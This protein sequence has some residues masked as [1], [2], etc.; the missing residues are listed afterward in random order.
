MRKSKSPLALLHRW[1][2]SGE[3]PR[4]RDPFEAAA[5]ASA[6]RQQG[7]AG[8][9]QDAVGSE[10]DWPA[11]AREGLAQGR[12]ASLVAG[13]RRLDLAA[14]V[15]NLLESKGLRALPL[16]G[17]ALS[18]RLYDSVADR[19][20]ADVDV[21]VLDD[22][23]GARALLREQGFAELGAADHAVSFADPLSGGVVE[24]H[25]D[26]TSCPGLFPLDREG[27][28][29][30]SK[31]A[32]GQVPRIPSSEDLLVQISL[33]AA[34]QHGLVLSL[35]QYL[36]FRRLLAR[37]EVDPDRAAAI[38]AASRAETSVAAALRAAE[39]V[40]GARVPEAL[41]QRFRSRVPPSLARWL[42]DRLRDPL[43]LVTP[44]TPALARLRWELVPGRRA[45]LVR[46]SIFVARPGPSG[47]LL[48]RALGPIARASHL[49]RRWALPAWRSWSGAR[50]REDERAASPVAVRLEG[51]ET[52]EPPAA[53]AEAILADCLRSFAHVR[54]TVTGECMGPA[55]R[56]GDTVLVAEPSRRP[57]RFGDVVLF[58]HPEGLR[59]HRLVW[60]PPL[61]GIG[62]AWRTKGDRARRWDPH[63]SSGDVLG[64]VIA[65][66]G[67]DS[68]AGVPTALR[69][70]AQAL[71]ASARDRW[72]AQARA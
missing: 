41:A 35:V 51:A 61:A 33:H 15:L 68:A 64:T 59:L 9:L 25:Q 36:D 70:L 56:P 50:P 19:P 27:L 66:E 67:R 57:P 16:K 5:I 53:T 65:V 7:V 6:A 2:V 4:T 54:L 30:R 60:A 69:S 13:V 8:L 58:R 42:D 3:P 1:L 63:I 44:A 21:L 55:L 10:A 37:A 23:V 43:S 26:V 47:P 24:V 11:G 22:V 62:S 31:P 29:D 71:V 18:E 48:R 20:M 17:A 40:A 28:W 72:A 34:F 12:R 14:R 52:L 32:D 46:R 49:L 38:A 45:A 39:A